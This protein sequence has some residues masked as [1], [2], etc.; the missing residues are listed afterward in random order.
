[1][2]GNEYIRNNI[3]KVISNNCLE[4]LLD[5]HVQMLSRQLGMSLSLRKRSGNELKSGESTIY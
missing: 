3:R 1:M 5:I 2:G 4:C